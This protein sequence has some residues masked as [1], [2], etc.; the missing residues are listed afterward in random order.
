MCT[1]ITHNI[2]LLYLQENEDIDKV[3]SETTTPRIV[4]VGKSL[5]PIY[6]AIEG[7]IIGGPL[8]THSLLEV[9]II[10][11]AAYY[12]FNIQYPSSCNVYTFL[13]AILFD[14]NHIIKNKVV[15]HKVITCLK[16]K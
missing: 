4:G 6:I 16:A 9:P 1:T 15:V 7:D 13:E 14:N 10:L 3:I 8:K 11:V 5:D 12:A 2:F